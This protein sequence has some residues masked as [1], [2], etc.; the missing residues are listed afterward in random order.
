MG[1]FLKARVLRGGLLWDPIECWLGVRRI[2]RE[3]WSKGQ[4][5]RFA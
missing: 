2:V 4:V 3:F 5:S 1:K